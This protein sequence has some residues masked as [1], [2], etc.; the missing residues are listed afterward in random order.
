MN[1]IR[2]FNL[3]MAL[4]PPTWSC[5]GPFDA[6]GGY[7]AG[8]GTEIANMTQ[9][10][11]A[12]LGRIS[13]NPAG[14]RFGHPRAL[15]YLFATEMWERFSYYGMRALPVLY[16]VKYLFDPARAQHVIGLSAFHSALESV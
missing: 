12:E 9:Q 14:E 3:G 15:P 7:T 6:A 4:P 13:Q 2:P 8:F 1:P 5:C 11:A 10:P 16:M